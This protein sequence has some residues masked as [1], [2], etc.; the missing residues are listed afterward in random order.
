MK[1]AGGGQA[2][3]LWGR[4]FGIVFEFKNSCYKISSNVGLL[5]GSF[6]KMRVMRSLAASEI[7]TCSGKL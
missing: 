3:K 2:K 6:V 7:T 5:A 4:L 1:L